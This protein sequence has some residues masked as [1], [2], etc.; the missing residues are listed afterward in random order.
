MDAKWC[1]PH[2]YYTDTHTHLSFSFCLMVGSVNIK[3]RIFIDKLECLKI[4]RDTE[5][6][7]M[8]NDLD[9]LAVI[10][11]ACVKLQIVSKMKQVMSYNI[12]WVFK[13]HYKNQLQCFCVQLYNMENHF[14]VLPIFYSHTKREYQHIV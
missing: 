6:T 2:P 11:S 8:S 10:I 9:H 3:C 1:P 14:A 7:T 5:M 4:F 12:I 13:A